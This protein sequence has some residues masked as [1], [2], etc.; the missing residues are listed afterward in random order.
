MGVGSGGGG[1]VVGVGIVGGGGGVETPVYDLSPTFKLEA[2]I[3]SPPGEC[4]L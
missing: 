4:F 1:G 2:D 3:S